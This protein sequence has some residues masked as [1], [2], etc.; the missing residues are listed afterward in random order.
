MVERAHEVIG[1]CIRSLCLNTKPYDDT[2]V[3]GVLQAVAWAIRST[4]HTTLQASPAQIVFGRDMMVNATYP[5]SWYTI[6]KKQHT[7]TIK[8]N[9]RENA[10]HLTYDFVFATDIDYIQSTFRCYF[11]INSFNA[12]NLGIIL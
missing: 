12:S 8:N 3:N 5:A 4:Y 10:K 1:N 7:N 6:H 11:F 2:T 9:L